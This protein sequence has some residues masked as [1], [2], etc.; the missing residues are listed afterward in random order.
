MNIPEFFT[1]NGQKI[2]IELVNSLPGQVYGEFNSVT[3]T[4]KVASSII[5]DNE[6]YQLSEEQ[7]LNTLIH[8][9]LHAFQW[10]ST[11]D[12]D[13]IQSST[14]AGYILEFLKSTKIIS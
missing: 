13:E 3:N 10:F 14:Y 1:I 2:N 4:I 5:E 8:E 12:T 6:V 7:I 9:V 11:G